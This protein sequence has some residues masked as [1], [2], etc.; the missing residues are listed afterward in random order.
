MYGSSLIYKIRIYFYF[1]INNFILFLFV[2]CVFVF[3]LHACMSTHYVTASVQN[4][5]KSLLNPLTAGKVKDMVVY[6]RMVLRI[7]PRFY[8][9]AASALNH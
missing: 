9:K 4:G 7:E 3:F 2:P 5:P 6:Q 1:L 8:G